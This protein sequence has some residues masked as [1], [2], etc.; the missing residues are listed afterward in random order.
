MEPSARRVA[1]G[2]KEA[3]PCF[4]QERSERLIC[5]C[6]GSL[7]SARRKCAENIEA[8]ISFKKGFSLWQKAEKG[9]GFCPWTPDPQIL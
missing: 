4:L 5:G 3:R 1:S 9:Q 2:R 6:R 8:I 7:P